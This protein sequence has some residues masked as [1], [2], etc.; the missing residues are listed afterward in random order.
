MSESE[1]E[2]SAE[3][4]QAIAELIARLPERRACLMP[5]LELAQEQFGHLSTE[6][7]QLVARRLELPAGQVMSTATFYSM[8]NSRPVGRYHIQVCRNVSCYLRGGDDLLATLARELKIGVGETSEDGV[9]TL[10]T[11]ECLASCG[12]APALQVNEAYYEEMSREKVLALLA[13]LRGR[14]E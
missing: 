8:Y 2:F 3:S 10:S 6:I 7:L 1:L 11:V 12:T 14:N 4:E 5:V 13:E 9:F